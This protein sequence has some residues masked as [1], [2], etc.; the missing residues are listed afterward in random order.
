[1]LITIINGVFLFLFVIYL[2]LIYKGYFNRRCGHE[3]WNREK[4]PVLKA[5]IE[6]QEEQ[7]AKEPTND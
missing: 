1:M 5:V 7:K 2:L 6:I 4:C 3:C